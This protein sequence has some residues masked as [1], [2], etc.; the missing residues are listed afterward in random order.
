MKLKKTKYLDEK[1]RKYKGVD[2]IFGDEKTDG[3]KPA[4]VHD[5]EETPENQSRENINSQKGAEE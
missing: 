3:Q 4:G 5:H 2:A 1:I